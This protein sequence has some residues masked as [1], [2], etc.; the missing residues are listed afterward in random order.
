MI[1]PLPASLHLKLCPCSAPVFV[2]H[3]LSLDISNGLPVCRSSFVPAVIPPKNLG[4][5]RELSL[6]SGSICVSWFVCRCQSSQLWSRNFYPVLHSSVS[7]E[8]QHHKNP[9]P[10]NKNQIPKHCILLSFF[11]LM[12]LQR[13]SNDSLAFAFLGISFSNASIH[14]L[15]YHSEAV[16][17]IAFCLLPFIPSSAHY[18]HSACFHIGLKIVWFGF[19]LQKSLPEALALVCFVA[20]TVPQSTSGL[21]HITISHRHTG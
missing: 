21:T 6:K 12:E 11:P 5:H 3:I 16:K 20:S 15:F 7:S 2:D 10:N 18:I 1:S 17:F 13:S 14:M 19:S 8:K 9:N 4:S